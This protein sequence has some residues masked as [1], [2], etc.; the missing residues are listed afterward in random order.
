MEKYNKEVNLTFKDVEQLK[1]FGEEQLFNALS[2]VV[3]GIN[4]KYT[5]RTCGMDKNLYNLFGFESYEEMTQNLSFKPTKSLIPFLKTLSHNVFTALEDSN[6][7]IS[8]CLYNRG[9]DRGYQYRDL[10]ILFLVRTMSVHGMEDLFVREMEFRIMSYQKGGGCGGGHGFTIDLVD[11]EKFNQ[12]IEETKNLK[13]PTAIEERFI[14]YFEENNEMYFE[15]ENARNSLIETIIDRIKDC[16]Y[17]IEKDLTTDISLKESLL[18]EHII[19]SIKKDKYISDIVEYLEI[20][21]INDDEL[22][23]KFLGDTIKTITKTS[24][25]VYEINL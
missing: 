9:Y 6:S 14:E 25:T 3:S 12:I 8:T 20:E 2:S 7:F 5:M 13:L 16:I 21:Y 22:V 10:N 11:D 1:A 18:K 15:I 24:Y 17:P 23:I 19:K 4:D